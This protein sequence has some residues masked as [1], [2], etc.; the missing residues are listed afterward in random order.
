MEGLDQR[1]NRDEAT[2]S[3]TKNMQKNGAKIR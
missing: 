3:A 2:L 1:F